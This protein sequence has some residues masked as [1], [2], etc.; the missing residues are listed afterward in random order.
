MGIVMGGHHLT[1]E[2]A[3]NVPRRYAQANNTKLRVVARRVC[4]EGSPS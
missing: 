3:F 2:E 4:E 1:E